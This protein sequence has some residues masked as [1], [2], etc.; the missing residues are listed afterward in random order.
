VQK[1]SVLIRRCEVADLPAIDWSPTGA[2]RN[3]FG[4]MFD[5]QQRRG[6]LL[7]LVAECDGTVAGRVAI[8]FDFG[9]D[10][11]AWVLALGVKP[12][13]RRKGV[14][15][16]LMEYAEEEVRGRALRRL[17]LTVGKSNTAARR[18]YDR[19]G[20]TCVGEDLGPELQAPDGML[21]EP[22]EERWILQRDL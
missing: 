7:L 6:S 17:C 2:Y 15:T 12:S 18:L 9:A 3:H 16:K 5:Q 21:V 22:R 10:D 14:A 19:L 1:P 8:D 20:Y 13:F 4:K 11:E